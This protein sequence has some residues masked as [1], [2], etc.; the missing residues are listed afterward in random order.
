MSD[1]VISCN[2]DK[3][4]LIKH[5]ENSKTVIWKQ[6]KPCKKGD[7]VYVYVGRPYSRLFYRCVVTQADIQQCPEESAFYK[8]KPGRIKNP[9]YMELTVDKMLPELGLSLVELQK[10]GLKTVQCTTQVSNELRNYLNCVI[11]GK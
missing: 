6:T 1:Y 5:F 11:E 3:F 4:D 8:D 10:N 7:Y 2:L 9:K